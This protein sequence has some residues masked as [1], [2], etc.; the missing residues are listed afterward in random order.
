[1]GKATLRGLWAMC[2]Y[3][4]LAA[5]TAH[6][7]SS[8]VVLYATDAV[9]TGNWTRVA[10]SSGAAGQALASPDNGWST[11]SAIAAPANYVEFSF[12]AASATP[13]H[14]WV[15]MRASGDSKFSDSLFAQF[16]DAIS[17]TGAA[18]YSIGSSNALTLNLQT[19]N[20]SKLH[21]WGWVDDAFWLSQAS[22]I[23]FSAT[24][25]HKLRLQ[26]REDGVQVDQIVLSPATYLSVSP[27]QR[28][29][30]STIVAKPA[31]APPPAARTPYSG[32]AIVL[33][34]TVQA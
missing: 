25:T 28:S 13:Y 26:A 34:G 15:R 5:G 27:G 23:S 7:A 6:A 9:T 19:S 2:V 22:T 3:T 12:D 4:I 31:T 33:P 21:G 11:N 17:S 18:L 10:D 16:S 20:G 24:G 1:M 32:T 14:V 30:D 29:G 8:D